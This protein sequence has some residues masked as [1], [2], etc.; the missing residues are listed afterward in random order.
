MDRRPQAICHIFQATYEK[1]P[2]AREQIATLTDKGLVC[3]ASGDVY[4]RWRAVIP[5]LGLVVEAL[6]PHFNPTG[7]C[8]PTLAH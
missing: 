8:P 1:P 5:A 7:Y 4:E 3:A 2:L 6:Y